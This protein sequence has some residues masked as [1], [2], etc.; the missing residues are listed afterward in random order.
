MASSG[1]SPP[2]YT[3]VL[4]EE[5]VLD[6]FWNRSLVSFSGAS[7]GSFTVD[8][9]TSIWTTGSVNVSGALSHVE[10]DFV[11]PSTGPIGWSYNGATNLIR[12]TP[13]LTPAASTGPNPLE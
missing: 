4:Y 11:G 5:G 9:G 7:P 13:D 8:D 2:T 1:S 10:L 12:G 6:V 3:G